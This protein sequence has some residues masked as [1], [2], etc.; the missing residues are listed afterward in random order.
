MFRRDFLKRATVAALGLL[1]LSGADSLRDIYRLRSGQRE[2]VRMYALRKGD[3]FVFEIPPDAHEEWNQYRGRE[4]L[5]DSE[6]YWMPADKCWG[7]N[8]RPA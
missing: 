1:G 4:W 5:A 2:R 6:P 3:R 7:I 8:A